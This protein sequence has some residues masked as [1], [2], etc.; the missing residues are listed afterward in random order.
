MAFGLLLVQFQY[1][2]EGLLRDLHVTYLTHTFLTFLLFLKK[3]L[4]TSDIT[5]VTFCK[6]V[7]TNGLNSLTGDDFSANCCEEVITEALRR[8]GPKHLMF[9][10]DMPILRMRCHRIEENGT[11]INLIP[12]GLYGDP[13]QDP[14]LREVSPEEAEKITFFMYEEIL[15]AK[16]AAARLGYGKEE[17]EKIFYGNAAKL[18]ADAKKSIYG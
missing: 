7:F 18:I 4:L 9:G 6:Y 1:A 5:A 10:T 11:Y 14:H 12:P 17:I 3:F 16:R 15:A 2:H 13:K 8:V